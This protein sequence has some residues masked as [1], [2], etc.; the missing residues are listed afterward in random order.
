M[1]FFLFSFVFLP[2]VAGNVYRSVNDL[3]KDF[4]I[5]PRNHLGRALTDRY[6]LLVTYSLSHSANSHMRVKC[7]THFTFLRMKS[8]LR[9]VRRVSPSIAPTLPQSSIMKRLRRQTSTYDRLRHIHGRSQDFHQGGRVVVCVVS[10]RHDSWM[11]R[12]KKTIIHNICTIFAW[13][14]K[15]WRTSLLLI[16]LMVN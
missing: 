9:T 6:L 16:S 4:S 15:L 7:S 2:T 10:K 8:K 5:N 11:S 13:H 12:T 1:L 14:V 3:R